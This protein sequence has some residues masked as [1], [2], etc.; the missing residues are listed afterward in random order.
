MNTIGDVL[1]VGW[2][3]RRA[4]IAL[5]AGA[6]AAAALAALFALGPMPGLIVLLTAA[7]AGMTRLQW[8]VIEGP[9]LHLREARG[10]FRFHP[11][12]ARQAGGLR[13]RRWPLPWCHLRIA[14]C[15]D[16]AYVVLHAPSPRHA[17][18]RAITLWMIVHGRRRARIDARLL[19]ALASMPEHDAT[20]QPHDASPA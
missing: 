11:I 12:L 20:R 16:G 17:T 3:S 2:Q 14:R 5:V 9:A 15:A 7:L 18:S 13:F 1:A 10:G 4:G 8:A 19:D 6:G